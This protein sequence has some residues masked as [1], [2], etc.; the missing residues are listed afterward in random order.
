MTGLAE[1]FLRYP[2]DDP[3]AYFGLSQEL[4]SD[5]AS[6]TTKTF[7]KSLSPAD[8]SLL[9]ILGMR[10]GISHENFW[11]G[12]VALNEQERQMMDLME[13]P[14][15]ELAEKINVVLWFDTMGDSGRY[16]IYKKKKVDGEFEFVIASSGLVNKTNA[17]DMLDEVGLALFSSTVQERR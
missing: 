11:I 15:T 10:I 4:K 3:D 8:W 14:P 12:R 17:G 9:Q 5:Q 6:E 2:A 7:L 16:N 1:G 13:E